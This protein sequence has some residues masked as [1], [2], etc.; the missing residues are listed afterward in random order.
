M[1]VVQS[2]NAKFLHFHVG[3]K[4]CRILLWGSAVTEHKVARLGEKPQIGR[5]FSAS[6][7]FF[8]GVALSTNWA[9]FGHFEKNLEKH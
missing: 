8:S 2:N 6:C 9:L 1:M 3:R 5:F 4:F 7:S